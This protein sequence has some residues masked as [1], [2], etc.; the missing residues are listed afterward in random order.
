MGAVHFSSDATMVV[1]NPSNGSI[2]LGYIEEFVKS[3][4]V[5]QE[6][7]EYLAD[8]ECLVAKIL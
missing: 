4:I 2:G 6:R 5:L 7:S 3:M 1:V 8:L